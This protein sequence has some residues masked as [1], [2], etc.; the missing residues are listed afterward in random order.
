MASSCLNWLE[1]IQ[2]WSKKWDKN[3]HQKSNKSDTESAEESHIE[4]RGE[5]DVIRLRNPTEDRRAFR[6]ML[7]SAD[8]SWDVTSA[9]ETRSPAFSQ[10]SRG[11]RG[12]REHSG[13]GLKI[14]DVSQ[15]IL[16]PRVF[17]GPPNDGQRYIM[18]NICVIS[19]SDWMKDKWKFFFT[20]LHIFALCQWRVCL[21]S[22]NLLPVSGSEIVGT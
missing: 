10:T 5:R 6:R 12:K 9:R 21:F 14:A 7:A 13:T 11:Q 20:D 22:E 3:S 8:R 17:C 16:S 4:L 2:E 19:M 15:L 18:L 1:S